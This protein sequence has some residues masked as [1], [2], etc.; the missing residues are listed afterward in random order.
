MIWKNVSSKFQKRL[1]LKISIFWVTYYLKAPHGLFSRRPFQ[2]WRNVHLKTLTVHRDG[3]NRFNFYLWNT[4]NNLRIKSEQKQI[5]NLWN[6]EFLACDVTCTVQ[7]HAF[8]KHESD[9]QTKWWKCW[10]GSKVTSIIDH[11]FCSNKQK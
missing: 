6:I 11:T 10:R 1:R 5:F 4:A 7:N 9:I 3:R 8:I 2:M